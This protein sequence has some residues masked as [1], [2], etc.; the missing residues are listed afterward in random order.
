MFGMGC[1]TVHRFCWHHKDAKGVLIGIIC[2]FTIMP[3]VGY[4]LASLTNLPPEIQAGIILV[5]CSPS[6]LASNVMSFILEVEPGLITHP[7][8]RSDFIGSVTHPLL[9]KTLANQLVP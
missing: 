2:Q 4:T 9:M 8:C 5:G 6:G 1:S 3:I 7:H